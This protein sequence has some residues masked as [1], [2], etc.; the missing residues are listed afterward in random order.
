LNPNVDATAAL[1][2]V[3]IGDKLS[4]RVKPTDFEANLAKYINAGDTSG[5][6][7]YVNTQVDRQVTADKGNDATN[8][9]D[10]K[11]SV[12]LTNNLIDLINNNKD[13][14]GAIDGNLSNWMAKVGAD[15]ALTK[16]KTNLQQLQAQQRKFFAGSAVTATEMEELSN[17]I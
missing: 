2:Y 12:D 17:F 3:N 16:I 4:E 6:N 10:L 13:K 15:P 9:S 7:T 5:L 11:W 8:T 1:P 14:V